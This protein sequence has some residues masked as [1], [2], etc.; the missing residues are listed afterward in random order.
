[1]NRVFL[2][3]GSNLANPL[4]QVQAA[5]DALT[6][7]PETKQVLVSSFWRTPLR[8]ARPA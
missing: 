6:T 1:M 3:L 5:L 4:H 2:A 8:A 7:L